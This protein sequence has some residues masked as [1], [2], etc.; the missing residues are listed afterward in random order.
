MKRLDV[1]KKDGV[2]S[3]DDRLN[4]L[5]SQKW[6]MNSDVNVVLENYNSSKWLKAKPTLIDKS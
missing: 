2:E 1:R 4:R 3:P 5:T 6:T